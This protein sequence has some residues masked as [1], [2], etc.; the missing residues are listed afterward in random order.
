MGGKAK[1]EIDDLSN[2]KHELLNDIIVIT[3]RLKKLRET[4]DNILDVME[5][6]NCQNKGG[7]NGN[8]DK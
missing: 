7:G 1:I 6:C 2:L 5:I 4:L 3:G 8:I